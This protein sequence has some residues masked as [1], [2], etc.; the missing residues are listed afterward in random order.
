[1]RSKSVSH[2]PCL[3]LCDPMNCSPPGSPPCRGISQ[4]RMLEWVAI[5]FSFG[6]FQPRD[7]TWVSCTAGRF[8]IVWATRETPEKHR[9][10]KIKEWTLAT[11]NTDTLQKCTHR[12]MVITYNY[13][14]NMEPCPS[15]FLLPPPSEFQ[16]LEYRTVSSSKRWINI[17][18]PEHI[19]PHKNKQ[20][21][22]Y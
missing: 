17:Q 8:F 15:P 16:W 13:L 9:C 7:W 5:P 14:L 3:T 19:A 1:M 4:A 2:Q 10:C 21:H 18:F 11:I 12:P 20:K 22:M 6:S